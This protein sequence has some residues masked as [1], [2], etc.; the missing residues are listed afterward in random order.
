ML[1]L[2]LEKNDLVYKIQ[3]EKMNKQKLIKWQCSGDRNRSY[4][5]NYTKMLPT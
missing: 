2:Q 4:N 1:I 3:L 5:D